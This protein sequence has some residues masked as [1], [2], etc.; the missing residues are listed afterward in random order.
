[1]ESRS[2]CELDELI[3]LL[4]NKSAPRRDKQATIKNFSLMSWKFFLSIPMTL[5][6][7]CTQLYSQTPVEVIETSLKVP[8]MAEETFYLG[9]AEGDKMIFNFEEANG[10]DLKEVEIVEMPSTSRYLEIKTSKIVDKIITIPRTGIYKFRF[11][12]SG[13]AARICKYKIQRIPASPATQNFNTTVYTHT[14]NDTTYINEAEDYVAKT[15]TVITHFQ[16]RTIKVNPL[17]VAGGNKASFNFT[18]PENTIAWGFYLSTD[19]T[20]QEVFNEANKDYINESGPQVQKFPMYNILTAVALN[21]PATIL[22]TETGPPINY[23]IMDADNVSAFATGAQF[24][25]IKKG[26]VINDYSAMQPRKATLFFCFSNDNPEPVS[27]TVKITSVQANEALE[28]R[29]GKRMIITPKNK[30]YLKE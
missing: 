5:L 7:L 24:R 6:L 28:T 9:F 30:M 21:K 1:M 2:W 23:W 8:I 3:Q 4:E 19:K 14:V 13:I 29:Q 18:L 11:S 26:K 12:N 15:D 27:V 17:G 25:Y 16:D 20:G 22:R 10:K